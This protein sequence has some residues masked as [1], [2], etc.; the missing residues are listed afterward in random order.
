M[1][2]DRRRLE[3]EMLEMRVTPGLE[4]FRLGERTSEPKD[5]WRRY[6]WIGIAPTGQTLK[7]EYPYDYPREAIWVDTH[8]RL[9]S[10]HHREGYLCLMEPREW[11]PDYTAA[12]AIA[13]A[14]RFLR[15]Y[16]DGNVDG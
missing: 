14:F 1:T 8:P 12:T 16:L 13:I 5:S 2:F 6:Y 11:S 9:K 4:H 15:E 3:V 10:F 7:A